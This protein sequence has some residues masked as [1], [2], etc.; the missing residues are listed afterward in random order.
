M[1]SYIKKGFPD[2]SG[3]NNNMFGKTHSLEA[4]EK[5]RKA[6]LGKKLSM[7]HRRKISLGGMGRKASPETL[8]KKSIAQRG[9]RGS[10]WQ[11]G[12]SLISRRLRSSYRFRLWR[13]AVFKRDKYSCQLCGAASNSKRRVLLHADH[14]KPFSIYVELRFEISNGRTLCFKCH[15]KTPTYGISLVHRL[16]KGLAIV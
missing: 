7:E 6:R 16:K 10:N 11:G 15:R 8:L 3:K 9:E 13:E 14:I 4:R 2:R 12:K 1:K 5:I